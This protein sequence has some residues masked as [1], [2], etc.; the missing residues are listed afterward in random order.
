MKETAF[1][2]RPP[3]DD[4]EA[5]SEG[6]GID[7]QMIR[8]LTSEIARNGPPDLRVMRFN[9]EDATEWDV[10]PDR[11][12]PYTALHVLINERL[13]E[14]YFSTLSGGETLRVLIEFTSALARERAQS[15]PTLLLLDGT[16]WCFDKPSMV[17]VA[18]RLLK[19]PFQTIM[20]LNDS[21]RLDDGPVWK[22]WGQVVLDT[23]NG[24]GRTS[25]I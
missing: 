11:E 12:T 9:E 1:L 21:R 17:E 10:H 13:G 5:I 8:N 24:S 15:A 20:A 19:Q 4:L 3:I 2:R 25:I 23:P 7:G 6:L 16:G 18:R 14:Q 22:S